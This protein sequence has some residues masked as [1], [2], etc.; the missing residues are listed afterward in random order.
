MTK[1]ARRKMAITSAIQRI[2]WLKGKGHIMEINFR[3]KK[4]TVKENLL[5]QTKIP[6]TVTKTNRLTFLGEKEKVKV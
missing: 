5:V 3:S 1:V 6:F 4:V 2:H